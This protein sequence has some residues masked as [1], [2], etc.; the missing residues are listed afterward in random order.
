MAKHN[1]YTKERRWELV[2]RLIQVM[3]RDVTVLEER[4]WVTMVLLLK[5]K[6]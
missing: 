5:G 3:F 1:K 4:T 2:V 6:G